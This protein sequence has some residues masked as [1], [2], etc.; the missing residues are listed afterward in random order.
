MSHCHYAIHTEKYE[1]RRLKVEATKFDRQK[2][3]KVDRRRWI[4]GG[5]RETDEDFV[6]ILRVISHVS[7]L[8][9]E[10]LIVLFSD[11]A[12]PAIASS[13]VLQRFGS[14]VRPFSSRHAG[15]DVIEID[16]GTTNSCVAVM[17]GK[18]RYYGIKINTESGEKV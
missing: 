15:N 10:V 6:P 2:R 7:L 11:N 12:K 9:V 8:R 3:L 13:S 16:L 4:N 18:V 1:R 5:Q 17:E 14:L